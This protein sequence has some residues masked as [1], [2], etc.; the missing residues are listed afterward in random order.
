MTITDVTEKRIHIG[1]V[2]IAMFVCG[3]AVHWTLK[4]YEYE[5]RID[6]VVAMKWVDS[7]FGPAF[8]GVQVYL[9]PI[10]L[11]FDVMARVH[12][13]RGN[14]YF[15]DCGRLGVVKTDIEAVSQWGMIDYRDDGLHIGEGSSAFFL[16]KADLENHR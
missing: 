6:Q 12:I 2:L 9:E 14:G 5:A 15:H 16:P 8:Y 7:K 10:P 13:G 1:C 11:G 3:I 4:Y